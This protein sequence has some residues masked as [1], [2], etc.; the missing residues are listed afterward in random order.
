[1]HETTFFILFCY[2]HTL[3][4]LYS[5]TNKQGICKHPVNIMLKEI[6]KIVCLSLPDILM[7]FWYDIRH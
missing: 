1:M 4:S 2:F 6:Q 3:Y 5:L 7:D